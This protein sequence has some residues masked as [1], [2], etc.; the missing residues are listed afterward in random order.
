MVLL[1]STFSSYL[2]KGKSVMNGNWIPLSHLPASQMAVVY[3]CVCVCVSVC[4]NCSLIK[5]LCFRG[6]FQEDFRE[7]TLS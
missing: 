4:A 2:P 5:G 6:E 7:K 1:I 3:K